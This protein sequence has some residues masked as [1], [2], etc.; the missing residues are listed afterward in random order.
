MHD[1][2]GL[3]F[4]YGGVLWDMRWD[5]TTRLEREHGLADR[6]IADTLYGSETWRQI[7]VGVGDRE[8]WQRDAHAALE[9]S[10]G[11]PLPPLHQH[12]REQQHLI[13]PNIELIGRLRAT[14]RTSVLSNA[15]STLV[16]TLRDVLAIHDLFDD[17]VCSADAGLAKPDPRIYALAA[18]RLG[19][20]PRECVFVDD[21][22]RNT[23]AAQDAG[24]HAILFRVDRGDSLADQLA[25]LGVRPA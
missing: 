9:A 12:W 4:D 8:S 6:T 7:A 18:S 22:E 17:I 13:T 15:D 16:A 21:M 2:K 23:S 14:Y 19:L 25:D 20:E 11:R 24:M 1:I 3:I 5:V 10:A